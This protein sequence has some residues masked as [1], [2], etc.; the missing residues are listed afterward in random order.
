MAQQH[1][2]PHAYPMSPECEFANPS[3][4]YDQNF[5]EGKTGR[6][7][8]SSPPFQ[9]AGFRCFLLWDGRTFLE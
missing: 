3:K 8:P 2:L 5:G 7:I 4:I 6:D 1:S 9:I